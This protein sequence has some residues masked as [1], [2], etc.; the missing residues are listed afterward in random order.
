VLKSLTRSSDRGKED[1]SGRWVLVKRK[2]KESW[3][4]AWGVPESVFKSELDL[5][6]E[7]N[8]K[9]Y[10]EGNSLEAC[11]RREK[12]KQGGGDRSPRRGLS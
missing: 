4:K 11:K 6:E 8:D 10:K 5:L 3:R 12:G 7:G 9:R 1:F 2:L